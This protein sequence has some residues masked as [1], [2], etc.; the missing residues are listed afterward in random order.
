MNRIPLS[1]LHTHTTFCDGAHTP[2]QIV[3]QAIED[4]IEVLGFSG[5]SFV[6]FDL[7]CCMTREETVQ[8]CDEIKRLR[9]LYADRICL[10]IGI[11]QD[12]FSNDPASGF[13]YR[14]GSVHYLPS[15]NGYVSVD[16]SKET[17]LEAIQT[18]FDGDVYRLI[19]AYYETLSNVVEKTGCE[20]IGHFDLI[21]KFNEREDFFQKD[22]PRV[23]MASEVAIKAL[24]KKDVLFE[25]NTGAVARGYRTEPY[26]S[27]E[28]LRQIVAGGGRLVLSSDAHDKSRLLYGFADAIA[29]IEA[30]GAKT[31]WHMT[32]RGWVE[33]TLIDF[34]R[35][36]Q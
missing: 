24:L 8:Y 36:S 26:P 13:D 34:C 32:A 29:Y 2:E 6:P 11:E 31:L 22:H 5:H 4:G 28:L 14:I 19:E 18:Q 1:N 21:S 27:R 7:D 30:I 9:S 33:E 20:I 35:K 23:R 10:L 16:Q 3:L 15:S 12:Y 17:F 25:I